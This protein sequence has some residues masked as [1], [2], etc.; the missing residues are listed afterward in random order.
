M[1]KKPWNTPLMQMNAYDLN[2]VF[3]V[4]QKAGVKKSEVHYEDHGG[5]WS[6][7]IFF[8]KPEAE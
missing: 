6:V 2:E 3:A 8:Q 5:I 1:D 4:I 7:A